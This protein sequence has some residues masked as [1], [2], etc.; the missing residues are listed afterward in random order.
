MFRHDDV[1]IL[2][3]SLPQCLVEIARLFKFN[4]SFDLRTSRPYGGSS[5]YCNLME[6]IWNAAAQP[7]QDAI[8]K[9]LR[10]FCG[11]HKTQSWSCGDINDDSPN[12]PWKSIKVK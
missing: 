10:V 8:S 2:L 7:D 4:D 12:N 3:N 11:V 1:V 6:L 9:S 5:F